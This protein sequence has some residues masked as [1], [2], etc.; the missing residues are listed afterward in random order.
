MGGK[1]PQD[2]FQALIDT[3]LKV[4]ENY[5]PQKRKRTT[6]HNTIPRD[7]AILMK[8]SS[9]NKQLTKARNEERRRSMIAKIIKV[10]QL[11]KESH[12]A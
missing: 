8:K 1:D 2:M 11:I 7:R 5:I 9:L 4:C 10:E 12:D 6:R 3:V